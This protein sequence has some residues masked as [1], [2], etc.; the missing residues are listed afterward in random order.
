MPITRYTLAYNYMNL[1]LS[2]PL[3]ILI[4]TLLLNIILPIVLKNNA[5]HKVSFIITIAGLI[6]TLLQVKASS[7]PG[8]AIWNNLL[9][10]THWTTVMQLLSFSITFVIV[11]ILYEDYKDN[12][13]AGRLNMSFIF[14][15]LLL[16][17][18]YILPTCQ[19]WL[20]VYISITFISIAC[21]MLIY[22]HTCDRQGMLASQKYLL[23]SST[24]ASGFMLFGISYIYGYSG[25]LEVHQGLMAFTQLGGSS[26]I[27]QLISFLF[28]FMGIFMLVGSFPYQFWV[29]DIYTTLP[30]YLVAY[31][32]TITKVAGLGWLV[33]V[34]WT[35]YSTG[36]S[37]DFLLFRNLLAIIAT[38]TMLIGHLGALTTQHIIKVFAYGNIGQTGYLLAL[39]VT[40]LSSYGYVIYYIIVYSIMNITSWLSLG[41]LYK[42]V[43]KFNLSAY[44]GIGKRLPMVS[45]CLTVSTLAL[46]G[47]PPTAG[48]ISKF[49]LWNKLWESMQQTPSGCISI[50]WVV[51]ILG[52]IIKLY[53]YLR[54]PY[55]LFSKLRDQN[56]SLHPTGGRGMQCIIVLLTCLLIGLVFWL[57][58][59]MRI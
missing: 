33:S 8:I 10:L 4:A 40:D 24:I 20:M 11:V 51:T 48:F 19:H 44:S 55:T 43:H 13:T 34:S 32:S 41:L 5:I 16:I 26:S 35:L 14:L 17:G 50:L 49:A 22:H 54:I 38:I 57:P 12:R 59:D 23:Y 58:T 7:T 15:L 3:I 21:T 37:A 45:I 42:S 39:L 36:V 27:I 1:G 18:V 56:L 46:V 53:Y 2:L 30:C 29:V 28:V 9:H 52:T 47:L 6:L 31:L 25:S